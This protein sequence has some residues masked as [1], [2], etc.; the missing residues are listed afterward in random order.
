MTNKRKDGSFYVE[1]ATISPVFGNAGQIV[2][3]VAV[4]RDITEEIRAEKELKESE[5]KFRMLVDQAADMLLV[6]DMEGRIIDVNQASIASYGYS[7]EELLS[8]KVA[9]LDPDYVQR[10]NSGRFWDRFEMNEPFRF[11]ARQKRKDGTIFPVEVTLTKLM[12]NEQLV[13]M[14]LC[15]DIS[16]RKKA[17]K[18]KDK[19]QARLQQ[20]QKMEAI[21][22]LAG[23]I[24]HDFNNLL[25]PIVGMSEMLLEDI[26]PDSP[27]HENV[28]EILMAGKRG[29]ALVKQILAFSRQSEG[30][31]IPVRIQQVL[32]EVIKMVRATIPANINIS[33]HINQDCGLVRA[34]PTQVHQI[35]MNLITNAYHAVDPANGNISIQLKDVALDSESL[36]GRDIEAGPYA[37]LTVSDN[38]C[39]IASGNMA[40]IFEPYFTTKAQGK[41]TGIGLSTV[42]GIVKEHGGDIQVYSELG[43]GTTFNI[44]LPLM[45]KAPNAVSQNIVENSPSGSE[46]I[47]LVDDEAAIAKLEKQMLERLGYRVTFRVS[48]LEALEAFKASPEAYDLVITDMSMP[49][50]TGDRLA[51]E[52]IAI[53]PDIPIIICTGFSDRINPDQANAMGIKGFLMK[54]VVKA[55]LAAFVR[56]VLDD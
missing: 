16:D 39:G 37:L 56:K 31:K 36:A 45:V 15:R 52:L 50:M 43:K 27:E 6:H 21:G 3:F 26:P 38:G 48:S 25:F 55:E 4:K 33:H 49:N 29:S 34:D 40:K 2:N 10:E 12:I 23:G 9:A 1:A 32:K 13:I 41:G 19:I 20:A 8:M 18:E 28:Q 11:E 35:A 51:S 53:R 30:E 14:G 44:Y 46:R 54:P 17:E 42:Y 47:L 24:A 7:R 22:A 5:K